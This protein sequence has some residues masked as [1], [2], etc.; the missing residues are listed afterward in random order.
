MQDN[1]SLKKFLTGLLLTR[2]VLQGPDSRK[3]LYSYQV[4][5]EEYKELEQLLFQNS[6]HAFHPVY[7]K[8]WAAGFCLYV[9]EWFRREYDSTWTWQVVE[10]K[11][12]ISFNVNQRTSLVEQGLLLYWKRPVRQREHGRDLLGSLFAEGGLPWQLVQSESHGFGRIV[13]KGLKNYYRTEHG[14]RTTL[15]LIRNDE[16]YLPQTFANLDTLQILAGIIDQL[17]FLAKQYPLKEVENPAAYLDKHCENWRSDFPVPLDQENAQSMMNDWLKDAGKRQQDQKAALEAG[18]AFTCDHQLLS[19]SSNWS[20]ATELNLPKKTYISLLKGLSSTRLELGFFEGDSL[21]ARGGA[22]YAQFINN[23]IEIRFPETQIRIN[24]R[25]LEQPVV[26]KLMDNGRPVHAF[27]FDNSVIEFKNCPLVF[28]NKDNEWWLAAQA[29]CKTSEP[30]I[31]V[32][33]PSGARLLSG[34]AEPIFTEKCTAQWYEAKDELLIQ[35]STDLYR[36]SLNH[37]SPSSLPSLSG[38]V[39]L[40]QARPSAIFM[41]FPKLHLPENCPYPHEE[42]HHWVNGKQISNI[43]QFNGAGIVRYTVKHKNGET[44]IQRRIGLLPDGFYISVTPETDQQPARLRIYNGENL[45]I[46]PVGDAIVFR[47]QKAGNIHSIILENRSKQAPAFFRLEVSDGPDSEPIELILP[48]PYQGARLVD[49]DSIPVTSQELTTNDLLGLQLILFSG[50]TSGQTFHLHLELISSHLS[51]TTKRLSRHYPIQVGGEP[52]SLS[53]FGFYN[54]IKQLL[55]AIDHQDAYVRLSLESSQLLLRLN[56]RRYSGL[57]ERQGHDQFMILGLNGSPV[58]KSAQVEA[59]LLSDPKK[60]AVEIQENQSEGVGTGIYQIPVQMEKDGPWLIYPA[61]KSSVRF[62]PALQICI[63]NEADQSADAQSLHQAT[64]LFHPVENPSVID[65]QINLMSKDLDHSGWQYIA[66]VRKNFSHLPLSA[67]ETW[68]SLAR[69]PLTLAV[70]VFRL[71]F[72][73]AFCQRIRDELAVI[74]ECIPL[75]VWHQAYCLF[76]DWIELKGLPELTIQS[77]LDNRQ[78]VLRAVVSGFEHLGDY[79]VSGDTANLPI[80]PIAAVLPAWYQDLRRYHESN[81]QWPTDLG[82]ELRAWIQHQDLPDPI[83][84][85][86]NA[87]YTH[88]VAL[89]PIYMAYVTAGKVPFSKICSDEIY[90]NYCIST[91]SDFDRSNWYAPVH[92]M[93][94][95]YLLA[96]DA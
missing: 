64:K 54:D 9:S 60:P 94:V 69:N 84:L 52:S 78:H 7:G 2:L 92:A 37:H 85:M 80:A 27:H 76:R 12:G 87:T 8:H 31:R 20:I 58:Q 81:D 10:N 62:R 13:R 49:S 63:R 15:D 40:Y 29:S 48:Y 72:D 73:E 88:S 44:V 35:K 23:Q 38:K 19:E 24:R 77:L 75:T 39:S 93:M 86:S 95:A 26:L 32:R 42:L 53:L 36:I 90:L 89:S 14:L 61:P 4:Q 16:H 65:D 11:L 56:I 25:D 79:V 22:V 47:E 43:R 21:L 41:G 57:V 33:L 6:H 67:F 68:Q 34:K 83:K 3:P 51:S 17:M 1:Y 74:W 71:Q 96:S 18:K 82:I 91:I 45:L 50:Q 55:G 30:L 5:Y 46:Q 59:M 28:E 66:D 70:A